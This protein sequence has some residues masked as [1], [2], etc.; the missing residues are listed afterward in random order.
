MEGA[1]R[2]VL[3]VACIYG[4]IILLIFT[5]GDYGT[6]F[7]DFNAIGRITLFIAIG[8]FVLFVLRE[9]GKAM[10]AKVGGWLLTAIVIGYWGWYV[11]PNQFY[12]R[13][14]VRPIPFESLVEAYESGH[15]PEYLLENPTPE[16]I[17]KRYERAK[18][19]LAARKLEY[20]A[21]EIRYNGDP[22][23]FRSSFIAWSLWALGAAALLQVV[24]TFILRYEEIKQELPF[25]H[26]VRI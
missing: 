21:A 13:A 25:F 1:R 23:Y 26:R 16:E 12:D 6:P 4:L 22:Q 18:V 14:F 11:H 3:T 15:H 2:T 24:S 17:Q 10:L 9:Q 8:V 20:R 5:R 7:L 19:E